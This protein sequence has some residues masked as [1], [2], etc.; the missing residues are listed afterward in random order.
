MPEPKFVPNWFEAETPLRTFRSLFKWNDM[1]AFRHPN[2]GLYELLKQTF[3]LTDADFTQPSLALEPF[4]LVLPSALPA[5][6]ASALKAIV[7]KEN[8]SEDTYTRARA[9]YGAGMLDALRLRHRIVENIP[10]VVL[11]PRH[12]EDVQ[13]ILKYCDEH[14]IPLYVYGGGSTVTRGMEAVKGGI[15]LDFS[16]HMKKVLAFNETDQTIT[17][18]PGIWGPDLERALNN[19]PEV[20][21][22]ARRYTLGH[23]PQ[24]FDHSSVGGWIVTRGAGQNST[25]YGKIEDMVLAQE[26]VTPRGV[27]KTPPYPRAATGP[28][29]DQIMIGSEGCFGILTEATLRVCRHQPGNTRRFSYLFKTWEEAVS[30]VR[31]IMQNENGYPSV[32]RL[33]DPEETDVAMRTYHIHDTP[34]DSILRRLGYHPMKRCLLLG[35]T[36]GGRGYARMVARNVRS[37]CHHFSAFNLTPFK[38]TQAWERGRFTDPYIREDLMDFGILID[39]L[40]CGVTWDQVFKVHRE[41]RA[42]VKQRPHTICMTHCSH[43]YPQGTNLYFIFVAKMDT[44]NEYLALQYSILDAIQRAGA[45]MSHHHGIG[46]QTAPWLEQQIGTESMDVLRVL[47]NYFDPRKILNPGG[48][49]GLDMDEIQRTKRWGFRSE[50]K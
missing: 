31:E 19:A 14:A 4:D 30:A 15:C 28:D 12:K 33:S 39:T 42:V 24:S 20:L 17:V 49:L 34:A 21:G 5:S 11:K 26:Y 47:K 16:A 10:D 2:R 27:L 41:V 22:A 48:T 32:F 37:V 6:R 46:K 18:Q 23:F 25:Y 1:K 40:E 7:G 44:I 9:S 29:F 35:T 43:V 38:V 3:D 50:E 8:Y 45:S 36:D 13:A